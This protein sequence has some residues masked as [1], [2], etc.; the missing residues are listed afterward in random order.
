MARPDVFANRPDDR[1]GDPLAGRERDLRPVLVT[2]EGALGGTLEM[3][4]G[5]AARLGFDQF[6][7][8][9]FEQC[10]DVVAD[11]AERLPELLGELV[12]ARDASWR[13]VRM[14]IRSGCASAFASFW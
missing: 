8:V 5:A 4:D 7:A 6:D 11:V 3:L 13:E 10:F 12:G 2:E 9:E 14:R 1:S